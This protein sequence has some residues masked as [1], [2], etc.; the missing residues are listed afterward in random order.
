MKTIVHL[1]AASVVLSAATAS[2]DNFVEAADVSAATPLSGYTGV[3]GTR[4][5]VE[6]ADIPVGAVVQVSHLGFYAGIAGQFTGAGVVDYDH[7]VTLSG[8]YDYTNRKGDY[9]TLELAAVTVPA[10]N[11]VDASGWSWV[12]LPT[13]INLIGGQYYMIVTTV[14]TAEPEDPYFNPDV[15]PGGTASLIAPNSIFYNGGDNDAYMVGRYGFG[16]GA[17]AYNG[18]G[19]LGANFQYQLAYPPIIETGLEPVTG[20]LTGSDLTLTV[21]VNPAASPAP[22]YLWEFD[23]LPIDGVWTPIGT[24]TTHQILNASSADHGNYRVTVSNIAGSDQSTGLVGVGPDTDNDGIIDPFETNTGTYISPDDTGTD[25]TLEDTDGDNINDGNEIFIHGTDPTLADTDDDDLNDDLEIFTYG[26]DPLLQDTDDDG[27]FDGEEVNTYFTD[28]LDRD[29]D[30]DG[31]TDGY[32]VLTGSTDP[33]DSESPGGP[34]PLAIAV[35]FNNQFGELTNYPLDPATYAGVPAVSQKNWNRTNPDGFPAAGTEAN[36]IQPSSGILV[37]ST[38]ADTAVTM[39]YSATGAWSD[40]N[41]LETPYG[42]LFNAFIYND[43][44]NPAVSISLDN[45]PYSAYDVYVYVGADVNGRTGTVSSGATTFSFTTAA[46]ASEPGG[47]SDYVQTTDPSGFPDANYAVFENQSG[48][49]FSFTVDHVTGNT[50][51]FGLQI[52]DT[53]GS[54]NAYQSWA[55]ANNLDPEGDGA[56]GFDKE[57]DG[58]VNLLEYAFFTDPNDGSSIPVF[59]TATDGANVS[60]TYQRAKAA[61]GL[62]YTAQWSDDLVEWFVTDL[63][64]LPTGNETVDTVEHVITSSQDG[65]PRKFLRV[66][67]SQASP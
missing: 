34:N 22:D 10:S 59:T 16:A 2:A 54:P 7:T 47:L 15:G 56:P 11:P 13:P 64:D 46:S 30:D 41:E 66:E 39:S 4:F 61:T 21:T 43:S 31:F 28:P 32:E 57:N 17:E 26:T 52:V 67:V 62:T 6:A 14:S 23:D 44:V 24:G 50:G 58:A 53:T 19:Y 63:T 40:A 38:G 12:E 65:E 1:L 60:V 29:S 48:S 49:S 55:L 51:V 20:L 27:L 8:S 35:A 37:D 25:P 45:I 18:T 36:I 33:N 42:H 9:S 5:G 3:V